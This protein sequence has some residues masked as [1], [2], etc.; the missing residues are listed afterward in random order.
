MS[1]YKSPSDHSN[2]SDD[3]VDRNAAYSN[4]RPIY[5]ETF[6]KIC[7]DR[8]VESSVREPSVKILDLRVQSEDGILEC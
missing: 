5:T 6:K 4:D 2:L 7:E 3:P 8:S 1:G